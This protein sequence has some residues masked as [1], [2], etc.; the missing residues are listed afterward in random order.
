MI[1]RLRLVLPALAILLFAAPAT[2]QTPSTLTGLVSD[3]PSG[4]EIAIGDTRIRLQGIAA[5]GRYMPLGGDATAFMQL[6]VMQKEVTC[7]L[8][9]ERTRGREVGI[10]EWN[11][12]DIAQVIVREGLARD[13]P[14]F[15]G[16]RYANDE[17]E[18]KDTGLLDAYPLPA[19]CGKG[20]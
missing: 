14:R 13:C 12:V 17:R 5:P 8:T 11:G 16:G 6:L 2:A 18:A 7:H 20:V 3:V 10:C 1:A 19:Y 15:S 4:D 9:G